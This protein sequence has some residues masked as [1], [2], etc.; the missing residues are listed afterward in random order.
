MN[1]PLWHCPFFTSLFRTESYS[2]TRTRINQSYSSPSVVVSRGTKPTS[3]AK[4][5]NPPSSRAGGRRTH[6]GDIP[7][8]TVRALSHIP[9]SA[10]PSSCPVSSAEGVERWWFQRTQHKRKAVRLTLFHTDT[11][12]PVDEHPPLLRSAPSPTHPLLALERRSWALLQ[13]DR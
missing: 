8:D 6:S 5:A 2:S 10:S 4:S 7:P 1:R 9:C 12:R 11:N 13:L 3:L